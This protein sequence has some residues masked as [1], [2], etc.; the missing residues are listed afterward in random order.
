MVLYALFASYNKKDKKYPNMYL[1]L[2]FISI[3]W[4]DIW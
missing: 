4:E 1:Y 3:I 2:N